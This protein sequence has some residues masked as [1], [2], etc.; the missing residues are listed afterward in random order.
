MLTM[1]KW[2]RFLFLALVVAVPS[3]SFVGCGDAHM[4]QEDAEALDNTSEEE[5]EDDTEVGADGSGDEE[6]EE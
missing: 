1:T 6:E 5:E 3:S 2:L 4:S